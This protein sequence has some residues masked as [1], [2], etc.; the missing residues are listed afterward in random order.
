MIGT[1]VDCAN[2]TALNRMEWM[3]KKGKY[4]DGF[5]GAPVKTDGFAV[6]P[7][8]ERVSV[9]I[10]IW[11]RLFIINNSNVTGGKMAVMLIDTQGLWD[12]HTPNRMNCSVFGNCCMLSSYVIINQKGVITSEL[13]AQLNILSKFTKTLKIDSDNK[14]KLF[15]HMNL[16][17]RDNTDIPINGN[18]NDC[19]DVSQ[20]MMKLLDSATAFEEHTK[21]LKTCFREIDAFCLPTPGSIAAKGYDGSIDKI[22]PLFMQSL[23]YYIEQVVRNVRPRMLNDVPMTGAAFCK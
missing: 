13:M 9:G 17:N 11:R 19:I 14:L 1:G 3:M 23:G 12:P 18:L 4:I 7:G 22:S 2:P 6:A 16:L 15:Q 20:K 8:T 5:V 10:S 21:Q